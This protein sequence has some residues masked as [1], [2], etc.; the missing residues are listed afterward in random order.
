MWNSPVV[1]VV[2]QEG[3]DLHNYPLTI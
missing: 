1:V 3:Q 2:S